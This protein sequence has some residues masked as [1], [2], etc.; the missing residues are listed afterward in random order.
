MPLGY[1]FDELEIRQAVA[2]RAS[3]VLGKEVDY[4][5]V[6]LIDKDGEIVALFPAK[7]SFPRFESE[8][9]EQS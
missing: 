3:K 4:A 9:S 8:E 2:D 5:D 6:E 7:P 1:T